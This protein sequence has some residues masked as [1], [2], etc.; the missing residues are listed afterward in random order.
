MTIDYLIIGQGLCGTFL[1]YYL[2]KAG[3]N[4]IVIDENKAHTAS[5]VASGVINPVTGRRIVRTWRIE[6]LLP[7][8]LKAYKELENEFQESLVKQHSILDFHPNM[9][10]K[11]TFEKRLSEEQEYLHYHATFEWK[12]FFNY[13][14]DIGEISPC[15]LIDINA[16]LNTWREKLKKFLDETQV[17]EIM[18]TS[19]IFNHA[20]RLHSYEIV[21]DLWKG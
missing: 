11:E 1:S 14:F 17:N 5:K 8:A 12:Q 7:F 18:V 19:H 13:Y 21:S 9:Q 16:L 2:V 3:K 20:A 10:M 15:L 4:V 6:E